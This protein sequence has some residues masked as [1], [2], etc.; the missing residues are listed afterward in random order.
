M[1]VP[2]NLD[3]HVNFKLAKAGTSIGLYAPDGSPVDLVSFG[4]QKADV[5]MGRC[6]DGST[7]IVFLPVATPREANICALNI[8]PVLLPIGDKYV[9]LGE[10]LA[11]SAVAFDP[12]SP[13]QILTFSLDLGAPA[14]ATIDPQTG[15]FTWTPQPAQVP[16]T[17]PVIVRVTDNGSPPANASQSLQLI[18][19]LPPTF[20]VAS[21][22]GSILTLDVPAGPGRY[23]QVV[24]KHDLSDPA[25]LPYDAPVQATS[26]SLLIPIDLSTTPGRFFRIV[27][28]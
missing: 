14:G 28:M 16:G 27:V 23:Y 17:Y 15:L 12:E 1:N 26:S 3:L 8:A 19:L 22:N 20:S 6:P 21:L 4:A 11:F 10:T 7:N 5:S 24:Y 2:A 13:P 9:Y 25:W 18:T